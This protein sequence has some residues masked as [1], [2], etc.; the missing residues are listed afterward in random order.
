MKLKIKDTE[1]DTE[2][3]KSENR[4]SAM[5]WQTERKRRMDAEEEEEEEDFVEEPQKQKEGTWW[6]ESGEETF[7]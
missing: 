1:E 2:M 5:I 4:I 7:R 3:E 6:L